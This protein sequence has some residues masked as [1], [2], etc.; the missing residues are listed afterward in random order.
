M[1]PTPSIQQKGGILRLAIAGGIALV[2]VIVAIALIRKS[3]KNSSGNSVT[4][5]DN[6]KTAMEL[7]TAIHPGRNW[8]TDLWTYADTDEIFKIGHTIK[9]YNDVAKEY[10]NLYNESLSHEL[11]D[12]LGNDYPDF[13]AIFDTKG[14]ATVSASQ[15]DIAKIADE[16]FKEMDG[17]NISRDLS[18]YQNLYRLSDKDFKSVATTFNSAHDEDLRTMLD[19][20]STITFW[21]SPDEISDFSDIKD[22]II[23][24]YDT[25]MK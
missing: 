16:L 5:D 3:R 24:R 8:L 20:E 4:T 14:S 21:S 1:K 17:V 25:L 7:N 6:V 23:S 12:A 9:N 11:Q 22:K 19:G 18:K 15:T 13:L 2:G 10:Q